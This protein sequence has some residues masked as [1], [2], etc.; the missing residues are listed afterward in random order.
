MVAGA[1]TDGRRLTIRH[2]ATEARQAGIAK[3]AARVRA[4]DKRIA[5][6][7]ENVRKCRHVPAATE[8]ARYGQI[9]ANIL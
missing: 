4:A 9:V 3:A 2:A 7:R 8:T 5:H 1:F 6:R